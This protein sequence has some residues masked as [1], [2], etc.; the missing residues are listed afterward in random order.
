MF[1]LGLTIFA[2]LWL[3]LF[4]A[5]AATA[6]RDHGRGAP[7]AIVLIFLLG[8]VAWLGVLVPSI[9]VQVRRFHDQDLSGWFVLLG[10]VP[11]I[12]WLVIIVFMCIPGTKGDNRYGTD[13][14]D[15]E[16]VERLS[17]VFG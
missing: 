1:I 7:A 14:L 13:P 16:G 15:P 6:E 10:F 5:L 4:I 2:V 3:T 11:Y 8:M 9:A 12:G 17:R